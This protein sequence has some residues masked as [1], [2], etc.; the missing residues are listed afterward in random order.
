MTDSSTRQ[1]T[2][3]IAIV[4][5]DPAIELGMTAHV[6]IAGQRAGLQGSASYA[7]APTTGIVM[8]GTGVG[9][10]ETSDVDGI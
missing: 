4:D 10:V 3:R 8:G 1:Y 7:G 5:A 2:A 9:R 6:R